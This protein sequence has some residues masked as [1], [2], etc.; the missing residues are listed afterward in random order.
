[1]S[2]G[3]LVLAVTL[4]H[5]GA[6]NEL[7]RA[8]S[9]QFAPAPSP[10]AVY[11]RTLAPEAPAAATMPAPAPAPPRPARPT[12]QVVTAE[13]PAGEP[14]TAPAV[15]PTVERES[16]TPTAAPPAS[17]APP[18]VAQANPV[19]PAAST[20]TVAA[21][22]RPAAD[23]W[24]EDLRLRYRLTG[25]YRGELS[26]NVQ[27]EWQ[28]ADGRYQ[29]R[30]D[31]DL[32]LGRVIITSQGQVTP[33]RLIPEIYEEAFFGRR[34]V[35]AF[36]DDRIRLNNG[37]TVPLPPGTQDGAS[38]FLALHR[39]L[40]AMGAAAAP[41]ASV[42][43]TTARPNGVDAWVYDIVARETLTLRIDGRPTDVETLKLVPQPLPNRKDYTHTLFWIAPAL[44]YMPV[45]VRVQLGD[46][47]GHVELDL[48]GIDLR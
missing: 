45:R 33:D 35:V 2:L 46:N 31:I 47:A 23:P 1:M 11:T 7:D 37:R 18:P 20:P 32:G 10:V 26:A 3:A 44:R 5:L 9:P 13:A 38:Q 29:V 8:L 22:A 30:A 21:G 39:L 27:V 19:E 4:A 6:L 40:S 34:R 28:R 41:G 14:A 16:T 48:A 15:A 43:M 25:D 24:P 17:D 12:A 36:L 42:P